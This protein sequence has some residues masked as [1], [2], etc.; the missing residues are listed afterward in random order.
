MR[1]IPI[2]SAVSVPALLVALLAAQSTQGADDPAHKLGDHPAVV[3][4]RLHRVAG[5]DY[6]SKFYPHPAWLLLYAEQ[7]R[8]AEDVA[9]RARGAS[10]SKLVPIQRSGALESLAPELK[11]SLKVN[12]GKGN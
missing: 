12:A 7:P 5:Y 4:Q 2:N 8:N 10:E 6:A 3:V 1:A 9:A 11:V